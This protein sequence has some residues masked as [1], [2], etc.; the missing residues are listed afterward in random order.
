MR[1]L[2]LVLMFMYVQRVERVMAWILLFCFLLF[3]SL[4]F[5]EFGSWSFLAFCVSL[6]TKH[7]VKQ[8]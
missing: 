1:M 8:T 4:K 2:V 7:Q 6:S 5:F 3:E